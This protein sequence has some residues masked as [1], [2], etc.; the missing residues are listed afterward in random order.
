MRIK[1]EGISSLTDA[2]YCA[3]MG[4]EK[5]GVDFHDPES[6][7]LDLVSYQAVKAWIEGVVWTGYYPGTEVDIFQNLIKVYG[8]NEWSVSKSFFDS[9]DNQT[10]KDVKLYVRLNKLSEI[11]ELTQNEIYGFEIS[12]ENISL[13]D[14]FSILKDCIRLGKVIYLRDVKSASKITEILNQI[15]D[16]GFV[17]NSTKEER[18][19]WMDLSE[20]QDLLESLENSGQI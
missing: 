7:S 19:G 12:T 13:R 17:F 15:P 8:I 9:L 11:A 16:I 6:P 14:S 2:R 3:G 10:R 18:P 1:V 4:V 5:L 20:L